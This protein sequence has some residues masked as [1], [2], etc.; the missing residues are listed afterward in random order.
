MVRVRRPEPQTVKLTR[1]VLALPPVESKMLADQV[2]YINIDALSPAQVK[3]VAAAVQKLQ[4]DGAQKL[5]LDVRGCAIGSSRGRHRAGEPVPEQGP[6]H[7]PAGA[8]GAAPELRGRPGEGHHDPAGGGADESR[9][10]G[11]G[12]DSG[13]GRAGQQARPGGGR[14][15]L[16]R[17]RACGRPSPWTTA[18]RSFSRWRS[19]T[20][21]RA[22]RSRTPE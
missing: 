8:A 4:K 22:R 10:G 20:R 6:H 14:A 7:L 3:E 1:A 2:G 15:H 17:C 11:C 13:G 16:R 5:V 18:A 21:R 12:R 9:H 19:T